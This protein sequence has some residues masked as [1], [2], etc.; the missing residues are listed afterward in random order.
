M[1]CL[2]LI[3]YLNLEWFD[4]LITLKK[5]E[6]TKHIARYLFQKDKFDNF[7]PHVTLQE[8][9]TGKKNLSF[10]SVWFQNISIFHMI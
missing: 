10:F 7:Q 4:W 5:Y 3:A 6:S 8:T 1:T 2:N 9:I